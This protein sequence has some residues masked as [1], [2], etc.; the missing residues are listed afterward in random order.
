[1]EEKKTTNAEGLGAEQLA[2]EQLNGIVGGRDYVKTNT[3]CYKYV[4]S[5]SDEDWSASYLCPKCHN[6]VRYT[7]WGWFRCDPCDESWFNEAKL[8]LNL[9]SGVW[10]QISEEEYWYHTTGGPD[11]WK[12]PPAGME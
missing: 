7:G 1:M 10:K 8:P 4:G 5:S 11:V 2:D 9:N 12:T 3:W 6:P